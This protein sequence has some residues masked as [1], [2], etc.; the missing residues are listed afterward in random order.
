MSQA[1]FAEKLRMNHAIVSVWELN[2]ISIGEKTLKAIGYTF[3]V[4]ED[5]LKT[6]IGEMF[7]KHF[8]LNEEL[9]NLLNQLSPQGQSTAI[10]LIRT[11]VEQERMQQ[12]MPETAPK[13]ESEPEPDFPLVPRYPVSAPDSAPASAGIE[14][15]EAAG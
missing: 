3:G 14:E 13:V 5:W 15:D 4:N 12:K 9:V 2:K 8:S 10:A 11:L 7:L 6:G 1:E